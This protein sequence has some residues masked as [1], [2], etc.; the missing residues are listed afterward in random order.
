MESSQPILLPSELEDKIFAMAAGDLSSAFQLLQVS[1]RVYN[2]VLPILYHTMDLEREEY[3][4]KVVLFPPPGFEHTRRLILT[5]EFLKPGR[6]IREF[7]NASHLLLWINNDTREDHIEV[8]DAIKSLPLK[9]IA[10]GAPNYYWSWSY[11]PEY[12][13]TLLR[14]IMDGTPL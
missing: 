14:V 6:V 7:P 1:H 5:E 11:I 2:Q 8:I 9:W 4:P 10:A 3:Y 12:Q 13:T